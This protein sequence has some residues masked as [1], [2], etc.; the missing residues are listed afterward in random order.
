M[1][2]RKGDNVKIIHGKDRGKKG[3]VMQILPKYD[4]VVV[5]GLNKMKKHLKSRGQGKQRQAGQIIEFDAPVHISNLA[6]MCDKCGKQTRVGFKMIEG[7]KV[8]TCAKCNE[9]LSA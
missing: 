1:K 5:E 4:K 8:R 7:K 9:V 3:K 2:I 6:F